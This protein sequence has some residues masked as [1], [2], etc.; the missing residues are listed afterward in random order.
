MKQAYRV[1]AVTLLLLM[2]FTIGEFFIGAVAPTWGGVLLI[3]A[4][5]KAFFVVR[6]YM[7]VARVFQSDDE[8]NS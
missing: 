8:V 3:V 1:G 6:D 5:L 7:H 2:V 4:S